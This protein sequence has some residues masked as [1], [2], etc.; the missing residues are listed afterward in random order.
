M[1]AGVVFPPQ[2]AVQMNILICMGITAQGQQGLHESLKIPLLH[3]EGDLA[4]MILVRCS[5]QFPRT[6]TARASTVS[7]G[8]S[9]PVL[10]H[11]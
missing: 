4:L 8:G 7:S 10:Y 1:T 5:K 6:S 3:G 9:I 2:L 11:T